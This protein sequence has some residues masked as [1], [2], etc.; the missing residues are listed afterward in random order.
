MGILREACLLF[1]FLL[2]AFTP[3]LDRHFVGLRFFLSFDQNVQLS[4][5][6]R[7][8][9]LDE[10]VLRNVT[11]KLDSVLSSKNQQVKHL[12]YDIARVQK[13]RRFGSCDEDPAFRSLM[14][15]LKFLHMFC[16][17]SHF[18]IEII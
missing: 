1:V 14:L 2:C 12:K 13:V 15:F 4:E 17:P 6:M 5:I 3:L 18:I 11:G 7:A 9:Q 10:V 8:A 16:A